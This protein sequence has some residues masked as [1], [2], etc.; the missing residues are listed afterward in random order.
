MPTPLLFVIVFCTGKVLGNAPYNTCAVAD[1]TS[2][3]A[4]TVHPVCAHWSA[5]P[6]SE[7]SVKATPGKVK[8]FSTYYVT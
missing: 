4:A 3:L 1:C 7:P 6:L 5:Q 2:A 8:G